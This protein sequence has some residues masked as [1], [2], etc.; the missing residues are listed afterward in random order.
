V[1]SCFKQ[2]VFPPNGKGLAL[3]IVNKA[4]NEFSAQYS[5]RLLQHLCNHNF[6]SKACLFPKMR[7]TN[8]GV[9]TNCIWSSNSR[10]CGHK[11]ATHQLSV[12]MEMIHIICMV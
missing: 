2:C 9:H 7:P 1:L 12:E 6:E 4:E 3:N 11:K 5:K 10:L 8:L